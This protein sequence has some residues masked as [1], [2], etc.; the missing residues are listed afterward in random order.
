[1]RELK[2][3]PYHFFFT[4]MA[5]SVELMGLESV[6]FSEAVLDPGQMTGV[7]LKILSP[8]GWSKQN[9]LNSDQKRK[10]YWGEDHGVVLLHVK[11][12]GLFK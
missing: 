7:S 10:Q 4:S 2:I 12:N 1:M 3:D 6:T 11:E 5:T 9:L 8:L